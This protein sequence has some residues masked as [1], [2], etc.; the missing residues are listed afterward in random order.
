MG[1]EIQDIVHQIGFHYKE[2]QDARSAKHK[3]S[4]II[5]TSVYIETHGFPLYVVFT[6]A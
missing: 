3:I 4:V 5:L 1:W 2:Y 6:A